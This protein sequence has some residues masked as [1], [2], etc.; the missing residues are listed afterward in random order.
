MRKVL[1]IIT[2][3][4]L[5][6]I[7]FNG[8]SQDYDTGI[9]VRAGVAW[10]LTVKHFITTDATGELLL[11]SRFNGLNATALFEKY[12]P[13]FDT[14]GFYFFFGGGAHLGFWN[15]EQHVFL[16]DVKAFTGIDGI[17]GLEYVLQNIPLSVGLD[18]KP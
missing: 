18:W 4:I 7:S 11:T 17:V 9:G 15:L 2:I 10:G 8:F 12:I 16:T 6:E 14:E 5:P 3:A 13:V 1:I